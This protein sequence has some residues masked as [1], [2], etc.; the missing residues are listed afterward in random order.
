MFP[1]DLVKIIFEYCNSYEY[2]NALYINDINDK[3]ILP[4]YLPC[5]KK[6]YNIPDY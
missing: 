2:A 1:I 5:P 3:N 4:S 6:V